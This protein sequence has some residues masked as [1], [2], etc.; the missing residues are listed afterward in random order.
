MAFGKL[1]NLSKP[2]SLS[3]KCVIALLYYSTIYNQDLIVI[4]LDNTYENISNVT[5]NSIQKMLVLVQNV[6]SQSNVKILNIIINFQL[7]LKK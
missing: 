1:L 6:P 4:K 7:S 5:G 3:V 2:V